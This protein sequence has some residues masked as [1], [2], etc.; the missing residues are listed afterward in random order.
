[1]NEKWKNTATV[2]CLRFSRIAPISGRIRCLDDQ[3]HRITPM[4]TPRSKPG[5]AVH[6]RNIIVAGG[7]SG[8]YGLDINNRPTNT[9]EMFTPMC[10]ADGQWTFLRSLN[11]PMP[12][13][14]LIGVQEGYIAFGKFLT[15]I[16]MYFESYIGLQILLFGKPSLIYS[17]T[18]FITMNNLFTACRLILRRNHLS[19]PSDDVHI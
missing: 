8:I 6:G 2:E 16:V 4:N 10:G 13:G 9:V 12:L 15:Q 19:I 1:M 5:V 14:G 11:N 7:S 18:M 3:W 17:S